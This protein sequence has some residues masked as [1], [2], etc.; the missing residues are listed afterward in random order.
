MILA[1]LLLGCPASAPPVVAPELPPAPEPVGPT[2]VLDGIEISAEWDDG[3]TFATPSPDGGK[4]RRARLQGFNTL[5][6]YG[7]VHRWG[8]WTGA[9]LLEIAKQ[10]GVRAASERWTCTALPQG[11]GYGRL[12][13]DCP[14][15][16]RALVSEGLAHL[17]AIDHPPDPADLDA[18]REAIEARRGMW[19]KGAPE[20]V[21]T[22]L[23]ATTEKPEEPEAYDRVVST[24]TGLASK[25][26][27]SEAHATC[28]EVCRGG[29]CMLYV[30]YA[31]RYRSETKAACL[32]MDGAT[33]AAA[34][35]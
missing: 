35:R 2:V 11:G 22:S 12:L 13:V 31:N 9:E 17:F 3:D 29:S 24:T 1:A 7:P 4:P 34:P 20:L 28:T 19:A 18:Q 16:R 21:V 23:H 14:D 33:G 30:P 8:D 6:S 32:R 5:E 27:H 10:A 15:L 26:V 25:H